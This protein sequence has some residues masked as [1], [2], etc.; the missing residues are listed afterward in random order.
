MSLYPQLSPSLSPVAVG[1]VGWVGDGPQGALILWLGT[2]GPHSLRTASPA[3]ASSLSASQITALAPNT[4]PGTHKGTTAWPGDTSM[5]H[6]GRGPVPSRCTQAH[7]DQPGWLLEGQCWRCQAPQSSLPP[8][9][10][11]VELL[12][13][14]DLQDS[15]T[16]GIDNVTFVQCHP[17]VVPPGAAGMAR[18]LWAGRAGTGRTGPQPPARR[19][20]CCS[21]KGCLVTVTLSSVQGQDHGAEAPRLGPSTHPGLG[22]L[23]GMILGSGVGEQRERAILRICLLL[24]CL[25]PLP[26][27]GCHS[28]IRAVLQL[29]ERHVRLVPGSIQ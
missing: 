9:C 23:H 21:H 12:G 8:R 3:Q 11:Q 15:A 20:G 13:L 2:A 5:S 14:V 18:D 4:W 22:K 27:C 10:P 7:R 25:I 19:G 1:S 26:G 6:W 17:D 16:A 24:E 28:P 29:R